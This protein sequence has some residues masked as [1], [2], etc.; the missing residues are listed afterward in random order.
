MRRGFLRERFQLG[1][2]A[3]YCASLLLLAVVPMVVLRVVSV[4]DPKIA[5]PLIANPVRNAAE[6]Q[7]VF[8][9]ALSLGAV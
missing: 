2:C 3:G 1:Y 6:M 5:N 7:S 9:L 8:V 4:M